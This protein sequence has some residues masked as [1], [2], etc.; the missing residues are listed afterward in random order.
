MKQEWET[1]TLGILCEIEL[2][3]TPPRA[4]KNYWDENKETKN[5][6]LSISDLKHVQEKQVFNSKEYL[7]NTGASISKAVPK[8][9]L[10]ISFK[11]TLGRVAFAGC[12][13][14]TNEAI[15]AIFVKN[16]NITLKEY[17]YYFFQY[18]DW[19][20]AAAGAIK[21]KGKTL[22]KVKLKKIKVQF[23]SIDEQHRIVA[24]LDNAFEAID[25]SIENTKKN[26]QNSRKLFQ[27]YSNEIFS[28]GGNGWHSKKLGNVCDVL[29]RGISPKYLKDGGICILN[30]KCIRNHAV[31]FEPS[32]RHDISIKKVPDERFVQLGDVLVNSTGTGTL[33]RVAQIRDLPPEQTTVDSHVTIVR[34]NKALFHFEFFGYAMILIEEEIKGAGEGC[35]GQTELACSRL[36]EKFLVC[37]PEDITE[38][39][40][41]VSILD[42]LSLEIQNLESIYQKKLTVLEELKKSL[43]HQAF[44]GEL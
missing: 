22:N 21:I 42:L 1:K 32:R 35:G 3:K 8:G 5:I 7:S 12:D 23:P 10:L 19:D 28:K 9:T 15:A 18:Y 11:L 26:I 41:I 30:Q 40:R 20:K 25:I 39:K 24:L 13:L 33:G 43:L 2:G 16:E 27:S 38:Q 29:K 31:S 37:F 36:V 6:W 34:P 4:E 14:Y 44:S 17:L